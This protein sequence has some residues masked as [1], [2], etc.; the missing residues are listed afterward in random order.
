MTSSAKRA[1]FCTYLGIFICFLQAVFLAA[2]E[3]TPEKLRAKVVAAAKQY[4]GVPYRYGG[5]TAAGMDCSGFIYT[6][7]R[8]ATK[9]QLPRTA[10]AMYSFCKTVP[11]EKREPGDIVFFKDGGEKITHAGLY[12]GNN[13][14]IH[15]VSDGENTGVIVS[16]LNQGSWKR[17]YAGCGQFLP[18]SLPQ[19][20]RDKKTTKAPASAKDGADEKTSENAV[21]KND[22]ETTARA[23]SAADISASDDPFDDISAKIFCAFSAQLRWNFFSADKFVPTV[24]GASFQ[25]DVYY[26]GRVLRPGLSAA[27]RL[28]P[29]MGIYQFPL[30]VTL[31]L[32]HGFCLYAGPVFTA[33][34]AH[35]LG[36]DRKL[37]APIFPGTFGALWQSP[38]FRA[39]KSEVS[40]IQDIN[41]T[42]FSGAG[43]TRLD[44]T[45]SA[46]SGLRF[47]TGIR[48]TI[49]AKDLFN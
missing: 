33:G 34:S 9:V 42:V 15:A 8:E 18:P 1:L 43:N 35:S 23:E 24:T 17:R 21:K 39:D 37:S 32:P 20:T 7:A 30:C 38:S 45:E 27:F 40:F 44:F 5:L 26:K 2:Q 11:D 46:A 22:K 16:S 3:Q 13:Q 41:W 19:D 4:I 12:I 47:S 48:V 10:R 25:T 29:L 28:E 31:G 36:T 6:V 14:F 49:L